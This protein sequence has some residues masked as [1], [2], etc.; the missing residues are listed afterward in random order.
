[1]STLEPAAE[2]AALRKQLAE[3]R[4]RITGM[5]LD[6]LEEFYLGASHQYAEA[7]AELQQSQARAELLDFML[8]VNCHPKFVGSK[9]G[10]TGSLIDLIQFSHEHGPWESP[11]QSLA[12]CRDW[13]VEK[14][15]WANRPEPG[16]ELISDRQRIE[17]LTAD[18]ERSRETT[19]AA[20]LS[21]SRAA[22]VV[23]AARELYADDPPALA[24]ALN[25]A[26]AAYDAAPLPQCPNCERLRGLLQRAKGICVSVWDGCPVEKRLIADIDDELKGSP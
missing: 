9:W 11:E 8:H 15:G 20:I 2:L 22:S 24:G 17:Q 26:L 7:K 23:N 4:G 13:Y 12:A 18:L 21:A 1:M 19:N 6:Q 25:Q 14:W 5:A 16:S 10:V 3:Q